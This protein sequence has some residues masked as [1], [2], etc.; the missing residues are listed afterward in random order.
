MNILLSCGAAFLVAI[1]QLCLKRS[2]DVRLSSKAFFMIQYWIV[3]IAAALLF[4]FSTGQYLCSPQVAMLAVIGGIFL[5]FVL[6]I[7]GNALDKGLSGMSSALF[8]GSW[9]VPSQ[10]MYFLFGPRYGYE[11]EYTH[12]AGIVLVCMGVFW[13]MM[14]LRQ[15]QNFVMIAMMV[16][17]IFLL[18]GLF[19]SYLH[20][21]DILTKPGQNYSPLLPYHILVREDQWFFPILLATTAV[22]SS[23]TYYLRVKRTPHGLEFTYGIFGGAL[24]AAAAFFLLQA[25]DEGEMWEKA[26]LLPSFFSVIILLCAFWGKRLYHEL[27]IWR[28]VFL[29]IAG[30]LIGT[31]DWDYFV[32]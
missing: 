21:H 19:F 30:V 1:A 22:M 11:Y 15:H 16:G 27:I 32:T 12:V 28:P 6:L 13:L 24:Y 2:V 5:W 10:L 23:I 20:W 4:P 9:I 17:A 3:A 26:A 31:T 7:S 29:I 14:T 18:Q 25:F 8:W